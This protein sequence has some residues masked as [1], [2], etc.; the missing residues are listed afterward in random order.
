MLFN[1]S[2]RTLLLMNIGWKWKMCITIESGKHS[3]SEGSKSSSSF[4]ISSAEYQ[5]EESGSNA[6]TTPIGSW[7]YRRGLTRNFSSCL[8]TLEDQNL[9][10][11]WICSLN[12]VNE[13]LFQFFCLLRSVCELVEVQSHLVGDFVVMKRR[14]KLKKQSKSSRSYH[15]EVFVWFNML[16]KLSRSSSVAP[17]VHTK[18]LSFHKLTLISCSL[19]DTSPRT[20]HTK[21][22]HWQALKCHWQLSMLQHHHHNLTVLKSFWHKKERTLQTWREQLYLTE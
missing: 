2:H 20:L 13:V 16:S 12:V 17:K 4:W 10:E 11:R 15:V 3:N 8:L 1:S 7:G 18:C 9:E 6:S 14:N 22:V 19:W 21:R 5:N